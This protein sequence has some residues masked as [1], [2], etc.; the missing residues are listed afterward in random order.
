MRIDLHIDLGPDRRFIVSVLYNCVQ[1]LASLLAD[2]GVALV[3]NE[4]YNYR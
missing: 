2:V 1:L 4:A 3:R